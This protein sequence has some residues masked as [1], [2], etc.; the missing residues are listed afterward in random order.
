MRK[1]VILLLFL[2]I[3]FVL[4]AFI[5][6][7]IIKTIALYTIENILP[8]I[9]YLI[10]LNNIKT[11]FETFVASDNEI[12]NL[13]IR[14]YKGV[15]VKIPSS[16]Y[17]VYFF[18][19]SIPKISNAGNVI[20]N[21]IERN[22]NISY[23]FDPS[24]FF[25]ANENYYITRLEDNY[26]LGEYNT[27][28]S[29][30]Y[31]I[32][33]FIENVTTNSRGIYTIVHRILWYRKDV[34][35]E[36]QER[37]LIDYFVYYVFK[38]SVGVGERLIIGNFSR[39]YFPSIEYFFQY[40]NERMNIT[41]QDIVELGGKITSKRIFYYIIRERKYI[42]IGNSVLALDFTPIKFYDYI[43]EYSDKMFY[44]DVYNLGFDS[45]KVIERSAYDVLLVGVIEGQNVRL[46]TERELEF[47]WRIAKEK[48]LQQNV[49]V[50]ANDVTEQEIQDIQ[51]V[52]L[53]ITDS[54]ENSDEINVVENE[55]N[56][57]LN[58]IIAQI[59]Q[60]IDNLSNI[61]TTKI[62]FSLVYDIFY[63]Y[64]YIFDMFPNYDLDNFIEMIKNYELNLYLWQGNI[65]SLGIGN[66]IDLFITP[67]KILRIILTLYLITIMLKTYLRIIKF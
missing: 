18:A 32:G 33:R 26:Y 12:Y 9:I 53:D 25:I 44:K 27:W 5:Q 47:Y 43:F 36:V 11:Y 50:I 16:D 22:Y 6:G 28:A 35:Y 56:N 45:I 67:L 3:V 8:R 38:T 37:Y 52:S 60:Y 42:G 14:A 4:T 41:E 17:S 30:G 54:V 62:P 39:E 51:T 15:E 10:P 55:A 66:L 61:I 20:L 46:L 40:L 2:F 58:D 63:I 57:L 19:C 34:V 48:Y 7:Y 65:N 1:V 31:Q 49:D 24:S 29:P 23:M 59:Q 64:N 13:G 21:G